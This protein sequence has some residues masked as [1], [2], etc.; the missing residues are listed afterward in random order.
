LAEEL[1]ELRDKLTE[2]HA[3]NLKSV[4][5]YGSAVAG[6][7][8]DDEGIKKVLVVLD[9]I[10]PGDLKAAHDVAEWWRSVGNPVPVYFTTVEMADS[11]DVFPIEFIDMS[12]VRHVIY[13][14][15]PFDGLEVKTQNLRHQLEYELRAK[16]L[17][18]RRLYIPA[19]RNADHLARLMAESLDNFAVLFRHVLLM[20][21]KE[22]P[23]NKRDCVMM[24][25]DAL[26]LDKLV[27]Q[28]IFEYAPDQE[29]WLES[30]TNETFGK[31]LA[32]IEKVIDVV[33][34]E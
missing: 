3:E 17:R 31:Y 34:K 24:L 25:G 29:V 7:Q 4:V 1:N 18:L 22:A 28:R 13:G 9:R 19:S 23:F 6:R 26:Q 2:A 10:T 5:L 30:E 11:S 20:L 27:L 32:Q 33:D 14:K 16:L 8:L 21:G 12:Q 15:D